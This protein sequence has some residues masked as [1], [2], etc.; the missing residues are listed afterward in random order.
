MHFLILKKYIWL[1]TIGLKTNFGNFN[2]RHLDPLYVW[3]STYQPYISGSR[4]I[5]AATWNNFISIYSSCNFTKYPGKTPYLFCFKEYLVTIYSGT[6]GTLA[7]TWND[8]ISKYLNIPFFFFKVLFIKKATQ[9]M[10][11]DAFY[12]FIYARFQSMTTEYV[13]R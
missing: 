4:R 12:N 8:R 9:F 11:Y 7:I 13:F 1:G 6:R 10:I 5:I 2:R 3:K